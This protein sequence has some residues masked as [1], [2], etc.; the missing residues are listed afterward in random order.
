MSLS[1]APISDSYK[2]LI[3]PQTLVKDTASKYRVGNY[4][5]IMAVQSS[6]KSVEILEPLSKY[7]SKWFHQSDVRIE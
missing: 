3:E 5:T 7:E 6:W 2:T 4:A 1:S